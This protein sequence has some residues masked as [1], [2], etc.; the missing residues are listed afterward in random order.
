MQK[1][2]GGGRLSKGPFASGL[3]LLHFLTTCS[4]VPINIIA[5]R[6]DC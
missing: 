6:F 2:K 4:L 5:H 3:P 1:I